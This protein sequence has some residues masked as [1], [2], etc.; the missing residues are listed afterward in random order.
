MIKYMIFDFDGT[1]VDS[2][3]IAIAAVNQLAEKYNFKRLE[4]KDIE[5]LRNL[6]IPE[7]CK[8]LKVPM[9]R[10]PAI[11]LEFYGVYKSLMKNLN[12]F[13]GIRELLDALHNRGYNIAIISS[14]AEENIREFLQENKIDYIKKIFCSNNVFG[15]DKMIR[16]FLKKYKLKNSEVMYVGD[17]HRDIVACKKTNV[18]I[19]WVDWGLDTVEMVKGENPDYIVSTPNEILS[20][21]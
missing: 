20:I 14:N 8:Q 10:L 17:E 7:R 4:K 12:M 18:E 13:D 5:Y 2:Q 9:Y 16:R 21:V 15:K 6:S 11:A 3:D 19:I 1:L